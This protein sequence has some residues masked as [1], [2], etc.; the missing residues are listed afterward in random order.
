MRFDSKKKRMLHFKMQID[1]IY[2]TKH[3]DCYTQSIERD[4]WRETESVY[5]R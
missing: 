2:H 3:I 5:E 1:R 4:K